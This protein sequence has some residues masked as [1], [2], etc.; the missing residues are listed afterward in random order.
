MARI[1]RIT[2][3]GYQVEVEWEYQFDNEIMPHHAE[4]KTHPL[5]QHSPLNTLDA[6]YGSGNEAMRLHCKVKQGESI[7]YVEVMSL[8]PFGCKYFK[9][10]VGTPC[11]SCG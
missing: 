8:Y 3:A 7:Q 11:T 10:P 6:L 9:F 5:V 1:E 2:Q 4:L